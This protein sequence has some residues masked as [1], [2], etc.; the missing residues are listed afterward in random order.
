[1]D[2]VSVLIGRGCSQRLL[3]EFRDHPVMESRLGDVGQ[4]GCI[5]VSIQ[6]D[7][8]GQEKGELR[9]Q[10]GPLSFSSSN[11][12]AVVTLIP[13]KNNDF[14]FEPC[15]MAGGGVGWG[16]GGGAVCP[17]VTGYLDP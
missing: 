4:S 14:S 1:M 2:Q 17:D 6:E 3:L 15:E 5:K 16:G 12:G 13:G 9:R 10:E 11:E 7:V 8:E